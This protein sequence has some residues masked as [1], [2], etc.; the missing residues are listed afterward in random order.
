MIYDVK[1]RST[2]YVMSMKWR[3]CIALELSVVL[4][5]NHDGSWILWVGGI[6]VFPDS[7][8]TFMLESWSIVQPNSSSQF[9]RVSVQKHF[10]CAQN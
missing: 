8:E 7:L 10:F 5:G 1:R 4:G 6:N 2:L 3:Y 9:G